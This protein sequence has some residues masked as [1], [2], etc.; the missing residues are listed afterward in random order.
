MRM[1]E[2][3]FLWSSIERKCLY[4]LQQRNTMASILKIHA[5]MLRNAVETNVNLLTTFVK[6]CASLP[7][8]ATA[9]PLAGVHHARRVFDHRPERDEAFLCNSMIKA[10]VDMRQFVES[11]ILYR[12][13]RRDTGF[14]PDGY[15]FPILAKSCG[16]NV[17]IWEGLEVHGHV[18]KFG[19]GSSLHVS[20]ALVD[21][22]AKCGKM[23]CA[24]MLF[25]EMTERS[26]VSWTALICGYVRSGDISKARLLFDQMPEKDAA[27][28]NAMIDGHVKF[29]EMGL[30]KKLFDEMPD[31][32]VVSWTSMIYG[33]CHK[34]D[35]ESARL[36]F[37]AMPYKNLFSWNA[38]IGG[39]CQNKQPYEALRL[40]QE[41]QSTTSFEPDE[42]TVVS[43][44]PAIADLGALDLGGWV[45]RF[46]RERRLDRATNVCTALVD[47]YAKCGE[48]TKAKRLFD[49]MPGKET[50]SWNALIYG[51]AVN[52]RA[53]EALEIFLEMRR[54][55]HKPNEITMLG[56]LSACNH[57]G[58]VEEG[59]KWFKAMEEFALTPKIEHYGCMIDL[60]GRAGCLDEAEQL[61]ESMPH[62]VNG[63]ILSSF[64][65]ACGCSNDV[66]RAERILNKAV[67][68]EPQND[69][70]Y[71][72]LRNLYA[73]DER[74]R[75]VEEIKG[76]MRKNG[77][78]K[79]VGCSVI[80]IDGRV[81]EFVAGDRAYPH[82]K[83]L[84][85]VL[86]L[87]QKHMK[88]QI[89]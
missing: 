89:I 50:A 15:T 43:I 88:G 61:I 10:H 22:Y 19:F 75:D 29:G 38:M 21:M 67:K 57:S 16:L 55:R 25:E 70:N 3:P 56:V 45:H 46:I 66:M 42:V 78:N 2:K 40:F 20:T 82:L 69:G 79:E 35:V 23:D 5:F 26:L 36:L 54:E 11:F 41:M 44:L 74:W 4:L 87:L 27:L 18:S 32:N 68:V 24:R 8:F 31:K 14:T 85:F 48:I 62:K 63:I 34:G 1:V 65:F 83:S 47:M 51:F 30:A 13:L 81:R 60:L 76:L 53:R 33:Y 72:M 59:K 64:L 9:N 39:Y 80:E 49:E 58:L 71:V 7:L 28:F 86:E 17:A 52:G 37:D 12:D 77:A 84:H 73:I 6:T